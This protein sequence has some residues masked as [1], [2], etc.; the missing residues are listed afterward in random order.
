MTLIVKGEVRI[1]EHTIPFPH[2][3]VIPKDIDLDAG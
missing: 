1:A 2:P 3:A